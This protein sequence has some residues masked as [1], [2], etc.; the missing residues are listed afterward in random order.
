MACYRLLVTSVNRCQWFMVD[1]VRLVCDAGCDLMVSGRS[2]GFL[3]RVCCTRSAI[4]GLADVIDFLFV[5]FLSYFLA[6]N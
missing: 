6:T 2:Y 3:W 1:D 5:Y 4:S